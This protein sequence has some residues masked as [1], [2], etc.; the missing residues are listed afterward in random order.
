[1][2][3]SS[4]KFSLS[5]SNLSII[6]PEIDDLD[7]SQAVIEKY[8]T[9]VEVL[10]QR[11]VSRN[12]SLSIIVEK[13]EEAV[14]TI[15]NIAE[16]MEGFVMTARVYKGINDVKSGYISI[17]VP[18]TKFKEIIEKIKNVA[19]DVEREE[20]ST[21]DVTDQYIDLETRLKNYLLAES[22]YLDIL[23]KAQT[24]NDVLNVQRELSQVRNN[25]ERIESQLK[26]SDRQV[27]MST[28]SVS[29][30]A[31]AE[32][33]VFGIHWRPLVQIKQSIRGLINGSVKYINL[34]IAFVVLLPLIA[35]W[36]F[37]IGVGGLIFW[38]LGKWLKKRFFPSK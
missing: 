2:G 37:T 32:V 3:K 38:K 17:K 22:K 5:P 26:Y 30:T 28:I 12:G 15:T 8:P 11:K 27:D 14:Q 9:T 7:S 1:V 10:P 21:Q 23:K 18:S 24:V 31:E 16:Q 34:M 36:I 19:I 6:S 25:I 20:I 35:V 13:S 4:A 33:E 29:L